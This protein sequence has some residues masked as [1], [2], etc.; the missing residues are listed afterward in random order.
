MGLELETLRPMGYLESSPGFAGMDG[1]YAA[2]SSP[3]GMPA[4]VFQKTGAIVDQG[5]LSSCVGVSFATAIRDRLTLQGSEPCDFSGLW[6]YAGA[7]IQGAARR[8]RT[9]ETA[10][11][12]DDGSSPEDA[13]AWLVS[14]GYVAEQWWPYGGLA[15]DEP[16][17]EALRHAWDQRGRMKQHRIETP[18]EIR[19]ALANG[20]T[21]VVAGPVDGAYLRYAGGVWPGN[22]GAIAGNHQRRI[23]GYCANGDFIE[24]GSWGTEYGISYAEASGGSAPEHDA[25]GGFVRVSG[26]AYDDMLEAHAIDWAANPSE[27]NPMNGGA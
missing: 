14:Y 13:A 4:A 20:L 23:V 18:D 25:P 5:A 6:V 21:V 17:V 2:V 12:F 7:R 8:G 24:A 11:L 16:P 1:P 9:R 27:Q 22:A 19:R 15:S 26:D 10:L 3:S